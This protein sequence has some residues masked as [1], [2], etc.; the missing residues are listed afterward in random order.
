[1][2]RQHGRGRVEQPHRFAASPHSRSRCPERRGF[3]NR[4]Y[5]QQRNQIGALLGWRPCPATLRS[6]SRRNSRRTPGLRE[7]CSPGATLCRCASAPSPT[8]KRWLQHRDLYTHNVVFST[9]RARDRAK[10]LWQSHVSDLGILIHCMNYADILFV[11][12]FARTATVRLHLST[13]MWARNSS[14]A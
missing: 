11:R 2:Y 7:S 9:D 4:V 3:S 1:M 10:K 14:I 8:Y 13:T 6:C 12:L 5:Q